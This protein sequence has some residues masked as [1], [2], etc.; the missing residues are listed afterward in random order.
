MEVI[1]VSDETYEEE[2]YGE[3]VDDIEQTQDEETFCI[4]DGVELTPSPVLKPLRKK[5]YGSIPDLPAE[6]MVSPEEIERV[7]HREQWGPVLLLPRPKKAD[8]NPAWD[9]DSE[10]GFNAF[11]TVDFDRMQPGFDKARY[12]RDK[13]R[14]QVKDLMIKMKIVSER[15]QGIR[16]YKILR[17]VAKGVLDA[18]D[19]ELWDL[20]QVATMLR[21]ALRIRREIDRLEEYS[22]SKHQEAYEGWLTS[23]D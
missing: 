23:L 5:G 4:E 14:E 3:D 2:I 7:Y 16:K 8:F 13:L 18:D 6:D 15:I 11:A 19:I 12:K 20:W 21:R 9:C 22:K 17:L 10:L 1:K